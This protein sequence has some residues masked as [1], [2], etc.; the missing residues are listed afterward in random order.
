MIEIN[1]KKL[2]EEQATML[3]LDINTVERMRHVAM[4]ECIIFSPVRNVMA[5]EVLSVEAYEKMQLRTQLALASGSWR[6]GR[7]R[8][9]FVDRT[10]VCGA[11]A[12]HQDQ[13]QIHLP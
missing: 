5:Y 12:C 4:Q 6:N 2:I 11:Y 1:G 10:C 13:R 7:I 8:A 9:T 3:R